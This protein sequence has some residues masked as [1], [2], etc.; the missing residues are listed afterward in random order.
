MAAALSMQHQSGL[1]QQPNSLEVLID[2]DACR[3]DMTCLDD[4]CMVVLRANAYSL[5][6]VEGSVVHWRQENE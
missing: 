6:S 1:R 3:R 2:D 4:R 5:S